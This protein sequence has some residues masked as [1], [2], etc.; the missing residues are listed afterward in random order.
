MHGRVRAELPGLANRFDTFVFDLDGVV[1]RGRRALPH[2]VEVLN[3][4]LDSG[5]QVFFVTNNSGATRQQYADRLRALGIP[6]HPEQFI[7]SGWATALY[8]QQAFGPNARIFVVGEPGLKEEIRAAGFEVVDQVEPHLPEAVVVGIDRSFTYE[9][10]AQAQYAIL[11]GARFIAT[12]ADATYPA[13]DRLLPGAGA[14]VA[15]IAAATER[16]PLVIG[17]PN[18]QILLPFI[19][20]GVIQPERTLLVG[21]RLD[22]DIALAN[23]LHIPCALVLTGVSTRDD[24]ACAPLEHLPQWVLNDLGELLGDAVESLLVHPA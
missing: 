22:T 18:P 8:L 14:L 9:R 1:Y 20:Q 11:N 21:D 5:R 3:L 7:T 4:L 2:A 19:E 6:A 13:E 15:A 12:N 16:R 10:L 17:K 23:A 24:V